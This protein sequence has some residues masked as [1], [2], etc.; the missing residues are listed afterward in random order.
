MHRCAT[1]TIIVSF[2]ILSPALCLSQHF[3]SGNLLIE[4]MDYEQQ[5][6]ISRFLALL[7]EILQQTFSSLAESGKGGG[8]VGTGIGYR[9]RKSPCLSFDMYI[10]NHFLKRIFFTSFTR[11]TSPFYWG[12]VCV[13]TSCFYKRVDTSNIA[14][15][16][17]SPAFSALP[18]IPFHSFGFQNIH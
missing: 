16:C 17:F 8:G 11:Y 1:E 18:V 9:R 3:I 2:G 15:I 13:F 10:A 12:S 5:S 4:P 6:I 14:L 7:P